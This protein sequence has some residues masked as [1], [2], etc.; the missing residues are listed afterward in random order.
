M[1]EEN[2]KSEHVSLPLYLSFDFDEDSHVGQVSADPLDYGG[3]KLQPVRG[4]RH[5]D[6][7][8]AAVLRRS[9]VSLE[10]VK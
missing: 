5:V 3:E 2:F 7:N 1:S 10:N 6:I 9:L 4:G 8:G